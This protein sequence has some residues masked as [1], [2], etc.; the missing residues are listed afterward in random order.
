MNIGSPYAAPPRHV[1]L[2]E[3]HLGL[4]L[5]MKHRQPLADADELRAPCR[6]LSALRQIH[7]E[8]DDSRPTTLGPIST[9]AD[10][11]SLKKGGP[12]QGPPCISA[13]GPGELCAIVAAKGD[14]L[15]VHQVHP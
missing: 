4:T 9:A 1:I 5:L 10:L 12:A 14:C 3:Q 15:E 8:T 7:F 11:A 2:E 13:E 6:Q